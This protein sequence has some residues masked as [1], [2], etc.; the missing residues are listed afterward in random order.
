MKLQ[1]SRGILTNLAVFLQIIPVTQRKS[2]NPER[3][4]VFLTE[5]PSPARDPKIK[6]RKFSSEAKYFCAVAAAACTMTPGFEIFIKR[7][8]NETSQ[9]CREGNQKFI[10]SDETAIPV[11]A[12]WSAI[13]SPS[14]VCMLQDV[15]MSIH[16][17]N[18]VVARYD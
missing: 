2:D 6:N 1:Y 12:A 4:E 7:A 3:F 5:H 13:H 15:S 11:S 14:K 18:I 9:Y 10:T 16:F 17:I 8:I